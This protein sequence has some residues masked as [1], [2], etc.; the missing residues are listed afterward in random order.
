MS[1]LGI[2]RIVL[3]AWIRKKGSLFLWNC[4]LIWVWL[5]PI[6]EEW[7]K[8]VA[9]HIVLLQKRSDHL[10]DRMICGLL[11]LMTTLNSCHQ[12]PSKFDAFT[13]L[14]LP[15]CG[16]SLYHCH[17]LRNDSDKGVC[18]LVVIEKGCFW[19]INTEI[20]FELS[21]LVD[22]AKMIAHDYFPV[23]LEQGVI[24]LN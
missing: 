18:N 14:Q 15:C 20:N 8:Q 12:I 16:Q 21:K 9:P 2:L 3:Y 11:I 19:S 7:R 24:L 22:K 17:D 10:H 4:V 13:L 6:S 1:H 5:F 23:Q